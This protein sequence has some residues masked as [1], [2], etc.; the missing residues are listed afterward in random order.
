MNVGLV[1]LLETR[2][3]TK[4][5]GSIY[6]N[7][8]PGWCFTSNNAWHKGGRI[9]V[10]WNPSM[11]LVNIF[12]CTSQLMHLEV[13]TVS[14]K[15]SF[16]VTFVY[17]FNEE[18]GRNMLWADLKEVA[19]IVRNPWLLLGDF[20]DI[21][22]VE[23][24][25]GS[26]KTHHCSGAF[27]E[28]MDYCQMEDVKFSGAFFT[29]NNKQGPE[30]RVY[31]KMDRVM[32][33]QAWLDR[34]QNAE[35][36]FMNEGSFDHCPALLQVYPEVRSGRKPFRYFRMWQKAP[37]FLEKLREVWQEQVYGAPMFQLVQKLRKFKGNLKDLNKV[38]TGDINVDV[39]C[40]LQELH[41]LQSEL[42]NNPR[43]KEFIIKEKEARERYEEARSNLISFL[44]Q[45]AKLHWLKDGD[46]NTSMFH[47][48]IRARRTTSRVYAIEDK[49]GC[50][51][52]EPHQVTVAFLSFYED[53][54][55]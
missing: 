7:M 8:F 54:W 53:S 52:H 46:E 12:H 9:I 4:N 24:R 34:Y 21:L 32:G 47:A 19:T 14:N 26:G 1:G 31:S 55:E 13:V 48:S 2:V 17:A 40:K 39:S 3:Q 23:E 43:D 27:K 41:S 10:S 29:W 11:F 36:T 25:I 20:N 33:N 38:E 22:S 18:I 42:Q 51:V 16:L 30:T 49:D 6:L 15:E 45:K 44:R 28:C 50:Q 5:L 37:G 35:V